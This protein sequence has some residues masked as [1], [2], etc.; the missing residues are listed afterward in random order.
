M[1]SLSLYVLLPPN[2]KLKDTQQQQQRTQRLTIG[3][4]PTF[5]A[6]LYNIYMRSDI[7][8]PLRHRVNEEAPLE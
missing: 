8:N 3:K 5:S 4:Y 6:T 1:T 7:S 2:F